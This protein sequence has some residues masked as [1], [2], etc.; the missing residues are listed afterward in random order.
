MEVN[1]YIGFGTLRVKCTQY[2]IVWISDLQE[3]KGNGFFNVGQAGNNFQSGSKK[4]LIFGRLP[5]PE[6]STPQKFV[7]GG[8]N[9][10]PLNMT[11]SVT[12]YKCHA[13]Y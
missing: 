3:C 2:G 9:I 1:I 6:Y 13:Q 10:L 5:F 11:F 8:L 4:I 12:N 7:G